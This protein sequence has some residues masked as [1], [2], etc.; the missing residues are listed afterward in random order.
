MKAKTRSFRAKAKCGLSLKWTI[1]PNREGTKWK[2]IAVG[3]AKMG[4][5][6]IPTAFIPN[7]DFAISSAVIG[8][9]S[10]DSLDEAERYVR[11]I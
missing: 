9:P 11:S 8:G 7:H 1:G 6:P 5:Q 4:R 2:A 3:D 10:F